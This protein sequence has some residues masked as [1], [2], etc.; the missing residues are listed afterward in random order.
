MTQIFREFPMV[1]CL[2]PFV[3]I[4]PT[5][6]PWMRYLIRHV[7]ATKYNLTVIIQGVVL[8]APNRRNYASDLRHHPLHPL[9]LLR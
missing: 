1:P 2:Y 4:N 6:I 9:H 7:A 3:V 5:L 8:R